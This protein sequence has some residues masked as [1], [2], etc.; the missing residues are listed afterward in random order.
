[1][2]KLPPNLRQLA[3]LMANMKKMTAPGLPLTVGPPLTSHG[4]KRGGEVGREGGG[5]GDCGQGKGNVCD[6]QTRQILNPI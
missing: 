2:G 4:I 5:G 6:Q 3:S 1:M